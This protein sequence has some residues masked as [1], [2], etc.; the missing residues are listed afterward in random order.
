VALTHDDLTQLL[1]M[2]RAGGDVEVVRESVELVLQALI[3]AEAT[4]VIGAGLHERTDPRTNQRNGSRPA[5]FL[6]SGHRSVLV[7]RRWADTPGTGLRFCSRR[8]DSPS[9]PKDIDAPAVSS[10]TGGPREFAA[11]RARAPRR[12]GPGGNTAGTQSAGSVWLL[13]SARLVAMC[14]RGGG[15]V[16]ANVV[17]VNIDATQADPARRGLHNQV[18][19]RVSQTPGYVA[20]YWLEPLDGKGIS[21]TLWESEQAA[22]KAAGLIQPPSSPTTGVKV[23]RIETREVIGQA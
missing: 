7:S 18:I 2:I 9:D 12:D 20:G 4:E 23:D 3:D 17:F 1:E 8:S 15:A 22:R 21:V 19:P 16:H 13:G 10:R 5:A 14:D 6:A 11:T